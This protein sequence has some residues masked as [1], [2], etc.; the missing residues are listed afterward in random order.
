MRLLSRSLQLKALKSGERAFPSFPF[1]FFGPQA[2]SFLPPAS[3]NPPPGSFEARR[4]EV[5]PT[6]L[7]KRGSNAAEQR[8][9]SGTASQS[10]GQSFQHRTAGS[11]FRGWFLSRGGRGRGGESHFQ[12]ASAP[13]QP[14]AATGKPRA[15]VLATEERS[16][17]GAGKEARLPAK[18][19]LLSVAAAAAAP[20]A[21]W[22]GPEKLA[23]ASPPPL[24][25]GPPTRPG[26]R[27]TSLLREAEALAAGG[28][29]PSAALR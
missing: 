24:H 5:P 28:R 2:L 18:G 11:P 7:A 12:R 9:R 6:L 15:S 8:A 3:H 22:F 13:L 25:V 19:P 23:F 29:W 1:R 16:R 10:G 21:L 4:L 26:R 17:S 14:S 27:K 20:E